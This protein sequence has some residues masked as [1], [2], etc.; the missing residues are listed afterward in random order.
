MQNSE[1]GQTFFEFIFL[2]LI[3]FVLSFTFFRGTN[4][5]VGKRWTAFVKLI[6]SHDLAQPNDIQ[7]R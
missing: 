2:L 1:N 4:Y 5:A 6:T 7:L 3:M